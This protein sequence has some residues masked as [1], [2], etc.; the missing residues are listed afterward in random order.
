MKVRSW[1]L[2]AVLGCGCDQ[3]VRADAP[4]P[5]YHYMPGEVLD[6]ESESVRQ[7]GLV[8]RV[9]NENDETW[10]VAQSPD[11]GWVLLTRS[12]VKDHYEGKVPGLPPSY[13]RFF[14]TRATVF[15]DGQLANIE[16]TSDKWTKDPT[17]RTLPANTAEMKSGWETKDDVADVRNNLVSAP[18][19]GQVI[20]HSVIA[21]PLDSFYQQTN[22][23][24]TT[25]DRARGLRVREV[26]HSAEKAYGTEETG[27]T[28]LKTVSDVLPERLKQL[29]GE[30]TAYAATEK[31][32]AGLI[33]ANLTPEEID[34]GIVAKTAAYEKIRATTPDFADLVNG[35]LSGLQAGLKFERENAQNRQN[36]LHAPAS[37]WK[38]TDLKGAP[39]ALADY[40]GQV[41]V[42]D[43]WYRGCGW[44]MLAMPQVID[45]AAH[46]A[47]RPVTFLGMSTDESESKDA[48]FVVHK[49]KIPYP[50]LHA[51]DIAA[52][53]KIHEFPTLLVL[54]PNGAVKFIEVGY[55]EHLR[56]K[57]VADVTSLLK[58]AR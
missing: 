20:I 17:G 35:E 33:G 55:D 45:A 6:Y 31:S 40:R 4:L 39:R 53:Y 11:G 57:V 50:T 54:D 56:D 1:V 21:E 10:V 52:G 37:D 47:G 7:E 2:V 24:D 25:F 29:D 5:R 9:R 12:E 48:D 19:P 18:D 15:P 38:T 32:T 14:W 8:L 34:A 44:C 49:M 13:S 16:T 41:V 23:A 26:T 22:S 36:L 58:E 3:A 42:L 51:K 27:T 43:F 28:T 30:F 46:F